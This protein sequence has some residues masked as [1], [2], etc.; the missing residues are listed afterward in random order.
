MLPT[1]TAYCSA[2]PQCFP[3]AFT[4]LSGDGLCVHRISRRHSY[5]SSLLGTNCTTSPPSFCNHHRHSHVSATLGFHRRNPYQLVTRSYEGKGKAE[6]LPYPRP[7]QRPGGLVAGA[8]VHISLIPIEPFVTHDG[9]VARSYEGKGQVETLTLPKTKSTP[10]RVSCRRSR[11]RDN[12]TIDRRPIS[13][14]H[15]HSSLPLLGS[16][17]ATHTSS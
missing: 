9:I 14:H 15:R 17:A 12:F 3:I 8:V 13:N 10:R 7:S 5:G 6:T 11:A 16:T 1:Q 4:V 2:I